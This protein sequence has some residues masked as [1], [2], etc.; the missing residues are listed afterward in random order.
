MKVYLASNN[1]GKIKEI[2]EFFSNAEIITPNSLKEFKEPEENGETFE[3]NSMIKA[4][5]LYNFIKDNIK[6][7]DIIIADDSGIIIPTLDKYKLGVYTKRQMLRWTSENN[8]EE[9]EFWRYIVNTAGEKS[10]AKFLAVISVIDYEGK[11]YLYTHTLEGNI[12]S[13]RGINGFGFDSIFE[14]EGK[15]LAERTREEKEK[16]SPRGKALKKVKESFNFS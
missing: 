15:T 1:K 8:C 6:K 16:I 14:Y 9:K 11:E 2:K 7:G 10:E 3:E 4:K 5:A 13:P 12:T